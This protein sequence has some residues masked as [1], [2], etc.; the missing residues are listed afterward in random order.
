MV[1]HKLDLPVGEKLVYEIRWSGVP[2]GRAVLSVK[3]QREV[4][5]SDVYHV[6]CETNSNSFVALVYPVEDRVITLIDVAG[7]YSRLFD[8]TKSEGRIKQNEHISFDYEK[9][10]SRSTSTARRGRSGRAAASR[11]ESK[12]RC[13]IR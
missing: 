3:W 4:E 1:P 5:G 11:S 9:R 12:A 6:E 13:R 2:A 8:M 7:G 10:T